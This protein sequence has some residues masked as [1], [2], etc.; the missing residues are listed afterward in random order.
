MADAAID[1]VVRSHRGAGAHQGTNV[2]VFTTHL[3][4]G[5][6]YL[7]TTP[8][9]GWLVV[10]EVDKGDETTTWTAFVKLSGELSWK[11]KLE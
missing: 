3:I 10:Y 11:K 5:V 4:K 2:Q 6:R 9:V 8:H 1:A 7:P